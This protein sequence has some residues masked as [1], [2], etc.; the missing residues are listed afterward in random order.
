MRYSMT[1]SKSD[2]Y[3]KATLSISIKHAVQV[4]RAINRKR[5]NYAKNLLNNLVEEKKGLDGKFYTKT[6]KEI[7]KTLETIES[8]AK[9]KNLD[10]ENLFVFASAS[11]GP[12]QHRAR[13]KRK[14]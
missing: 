3:G 9:Q 14:Q 2:A 8:N 7:L 11:K 1:V 5:L 12:T 10:L 6:A 13:R 4:C